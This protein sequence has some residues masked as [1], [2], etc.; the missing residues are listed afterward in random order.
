MGG[1]K[2]SVVEAMEKGLKQAL[3]HSDKTIQTG[4]FAVLRLLAVEVGGHEERV[5]KLF[6]RMSASAQ[7]AFA[8]KYPEATPKWFAEGKSAKNSKKTKAK[9]SKMANANAKGKMNRRLSVG[10]YQVLS[11]TEKGIQTKRD[12]LEKMERS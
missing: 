5:E 1:L 2:E 8:R 9:K 12:S 7:K 10:Q 6:A 4:A 11:D 3:S